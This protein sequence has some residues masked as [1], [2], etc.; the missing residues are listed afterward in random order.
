MKKAL[1]QIQGVFAELDKSQLVNKLRKGREKVKKEKY[2]CEGSKHYGENLDEER[3]IIK[4]IT[5]M[6]RLSRGAKKRMSFQKITNRLNEEGIQTKKGS[7]SQKRISVDFIDISNG[8][9]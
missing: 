9:C 1:I 5:Y 7:P 4:R 2:K 8:D 3:A 6:R